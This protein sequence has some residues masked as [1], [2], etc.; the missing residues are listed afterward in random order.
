MGSRQQRP[1]S[2]TPPTSETPSQAGQALR[3]RAAEEASRREAAAGRED[4]GGLTAASIHELRVHQIELEMQNEELRQAQEALEKS[5]REN[6]ELYDF[7]P[8]GYFTLRPD[9]TV[10]RSNLRGASMLG[11][12]RSEVAGRRLGAFVD[13][14]ARPA[15]ADF[16]KALFAGH[17]PSSCEVPLQ[18]EGQEPVHVHLEA[19]VSPSG[20]ECRAVV[21]DVTERRQMQEALHGMSVHLLTVQEEERG[22]LAR[23]LHEGVAQT[24]CA[25]KYLLEAALGGQWCEPCRDLRNSLQLLLPKIQ[26]VIGEVRHISMALR[27]SLLDDLGLLP[28]LTWYLR[29]F[30]DTYASLQVEHRLNAVESEIPRD[31]RAPIFRIVQEATN[32]VAKHSG[33]AHLQVEL[34]GQDG[35]LHLRVHDDGVGFFSAGPRS[36]TTGTGQSSMR[37]RAQLSGGSLTVKSEPGAGTTVEAV[38]HLEQ[39]AAPR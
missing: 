9:G 18:R 34:Q 12:D 32:N 5:A 10:V 1:A 2:S 39:P 13:S 37:D 35:T 28:T 29:E 33:A 14:A 31:L 25:V 17:G 36:K 20:S 23:E 11:L 21:V 15:F 30:Q 3:Q 22:R 6:T 38:W 24:L 27:P 8:V 16:L 7:A 19:V 26:D 4:R